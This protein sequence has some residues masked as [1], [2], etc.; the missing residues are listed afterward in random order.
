MGKDIGSILRTPGRLE[1]FGKKWDRQIDLNKKVDST[2][3]DET[4]LVFSLFN[5]VGFYQSL[6]Q[7]IL[8]GG[9]S[10]YHWPPFWLD[11]NQLY[12]NSQF[13]LL[14]TKQ[15]NTNPSN[16][17]S[18]VQWYFPFSIIPCLDIF[19]LPDCLK[20][21]KMLFWIYLIEDL[22]GFSILI[23]IRRSL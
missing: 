16:R 4:N 13:L 1:N 17:R 23:S 3:F 5:N 18:T 7:G 22:H 11:W 21:Y 2:T 8:K 6:D 14:F 9:V 15:T 12:D 19:V 20:I 10:L